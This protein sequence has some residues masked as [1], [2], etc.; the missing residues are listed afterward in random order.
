MKF[1]VSNKNFLGKVLIMNYKALTEEVT[2]IYVF[3]KKQSPLEENIVL[4]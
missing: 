3:C 4:P 1:S 2:G